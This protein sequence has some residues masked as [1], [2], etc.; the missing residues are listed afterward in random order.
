MPGRPPTAK[1]LAILERNGAS[2]RA[3]TGPRTVAG[4]AKAARNALTHGLRAEGGRDVEDVADRLARAELLVETFQPEDAFEEALLHR[5]A[6]AF[7]RLEKADHLES[8]TLDVSL[9]ELS[10]GQVLSRLGKVQSGFAAINRYRATAQTDL[11][12]AYRMLAVHRGTRPG[13]DNPEMP[14]EP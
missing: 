12:N 6:A 11:F 14:N 13:V 9:G 4:K 7:H 2:A 5:M 3:S 10:P 8:Q 1:Q